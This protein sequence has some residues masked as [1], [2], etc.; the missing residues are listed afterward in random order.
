MA[1]TLSGFVFSTADRERQGLN[2]FGEAPD[3]QSFSNFSRTLTCFA[4]SRY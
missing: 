1:A 3:L 2:G 4:H